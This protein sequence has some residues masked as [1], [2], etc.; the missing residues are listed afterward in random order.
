[1]G[2]L[3]IL[4]LAFEHTG[5]QKGRFVQGW[6]PWGRSELPH[7]GSEGEFVLGGDTGGSGL[8]EGQIEAAKE[9]TKIVAAAS[10]LAAL[11][12]TSIGD[13][14]GD[15]AG[16]LLPES[17]GSDFAVELVRDNDQRIHT[18]GDGNREGV[19]DAVNR[20]PCRQ[21]SRKAGELPGADLDR[22][23]RGGGGC[24][25]GNDS[26]SVQPRLIDCEAALGESGKRRKIQGTRR[27]E[28]SRK[29]GREC[30]MALS[31]E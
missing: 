25:G 12:R 30:D 28:A 5:P 10:W 16:H 13:S 15:V 23:E 1:V 3:G 9:V 31:A 22:E 26:K 17:K 21:A 14:G 24:R 2:G 20:L 8:G 4:E 29:R 18:W 6:G 27:G 11:A 19:V 7:G